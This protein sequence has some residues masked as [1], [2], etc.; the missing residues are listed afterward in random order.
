[1]R[2]RRKSRPGRPRDKLIERASI[3]HRAVDDALELDVFLAGRVAADEVDL[4]QVL[5]GL[6]LVALLGMPHAVIRPGTDVVGIGGQRLL[7]PVL[8]ILVAAELAAGIADEVGDLGIVVVADR[9]HG[10]DAVLVMA[11][12]D[13]RARVLI[14]LAQLALVLFLFLLALLLLALLA[15]ALLV[16][17]L[18][19]RKARPAVFR[20][21]QRARRPGA[22]ERAGAA[23][24]CDRTGL[25]FGLHR[26]N[27]PRF[28][29][30]PQTGALSGLPTGAVP[31][32]A[33]CLRAK[34]ECKPADRVIC[35]S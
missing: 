30:T 3:R 5:L 7:V 20:G 2:A 22:V 31:P 11:A 8:P 10:G 21:E 4:F 17:I 25:H 27:V 9:P 12:H 15:L 32:P 23:D 24:E 14:L 33:S 28:D 18:G 13:Q 1:M 6:E 34:P 35:D 26:G 16:G 29:E 19:R